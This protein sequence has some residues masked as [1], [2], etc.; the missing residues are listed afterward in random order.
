MASSIGDPGFLAWKGGG[1]EFKGCGFRVLGLGFRVRALGV[2]QV[3]IALSFKALSHGFFG[4]AFRTNPTSGPLVGEFK[5][6]G[7][8]S[9]L[10]IRIG[11]KDFKPPNFVHP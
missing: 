9:R 7:L 10:G 1:L 6:L 2:Y 3:Y 11:G 4:I 8:G 5:L